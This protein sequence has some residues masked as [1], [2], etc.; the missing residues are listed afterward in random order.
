MTRN[1]TL[2]NSTIENISDESPSLVASRNAMADP[3]HPVKN[4]NGILNLGIAAN[5]LQGDLLIK[6]DLDYGNACGSEELRKSV[7]TLVNKYFNPIS[8]VISS[9]IIV[10]NGVT[11][12]MDKLASVICNHEE[13]VLV[14]EPYYS[15]LTTDVNL[16]AKAVVHGVPVP[17]SEIQSPSQVNYYESKYRELSSL[18]ITVK[19]IILCNPHNPTGKV[20]SRAA[21]EA[22]LRFANKYDIY[23]IFDEI[24]ALSVYRSPTKNIIN[25]IGSSN[26]HSDELY[27]FESVLSFDNLNELIDPRLVV[28]VHGLSKDFCMNGFRVGWIISPFNSD[29]IKAL[30]KIS[31]FSYISAFTDRLVANI[32]SDAEFI[33]VLTYTVRRNLLINYN[34]ITAFLSQKN[35]SYIPAQAGNFILIDIKPFLLIWKN[36]NLQPGESPITNIKDLTFDDEYQLWIS[37][38]EKGRIYYSSGVN[39][40][41]HEPGWVRLI[42]SQEWNSL[43]FGLE[44]LIDFFERGSST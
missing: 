31:P 3:Y 17:P 16:V 13:A 6:K 14:S 24:Y 41:A 21:L 33:D 32:L 7:S 27:T 43:K 5:K 22:I 10:T 15:F 1:F 40:K 35:I 26:N 34:K 4:P 23:V 38:I 20:Y 37:S 9:H 44:R 30:S 8:P 36:N 28:V 12:A 29:I 11:S 25:S 39:I 2:S 42:F 18:G 19:M